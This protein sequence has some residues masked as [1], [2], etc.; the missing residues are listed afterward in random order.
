MQRV[1][2][3]TGEINNIVKVE[4]AAIGAAVGWIARVTAG[5]G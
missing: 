3:V 1:T 2:L 4:L 5:D